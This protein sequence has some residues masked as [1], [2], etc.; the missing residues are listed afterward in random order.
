MTPCPSCGAD[1]GHLLGCEHNTIS[2]TPSAPAPVVN[3]LDLQGPDT[4]RMRAAAVPIALAIA[5]LLALT[6]P[7]ALLLR[8]LFGMWLHEF[9]HAIASWFC[10][11]VAVPLP[12]VTMGGQERSFLFPVLLFGGLGALG[13]RWWKAEQRALVAVP[14]VLGVLLMIGLLMP[15]SRATTFIV[16][17]GD[18]GALVLGTVLMLGAMLLP[19]ESRLSHGALRWG[20]LVIGAGA[21]MD[22]FVSWVKSWRDFAD[23]PFGRNEGSGLSDAS[24]LVDVSG[25][26]EQ[27]LVRSYLGL[28][29]FCLAV[30]AVVVAFR[31]LKQTPTS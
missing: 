28:A 20:Y 29:F 21:F 7:G 13:W 9:G 22:V 12:W 2:L 3:D 25:W 5:G 18:G 17:S 31:L 16:F 19:D 14:G 24:R 23:L 10:G 30:M 1:R 15:F 11:V 4:T 8:V 26:S 27:G 6:G